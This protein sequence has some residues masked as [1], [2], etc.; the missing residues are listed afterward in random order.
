M[1]EAYRV[2]VKHLDEASNPS[3]NSRYYH[4]FFNFQNDSE[5]SF[6]DDEYDDECSDEYDEYYD[7]DE[8]VAF[9]LSGIFFLDTIS[10]LTQFHAYT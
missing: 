2:L 4:P 5:Y 8:D 9:Y 6:S 1:S 7:S 10:L 3:S